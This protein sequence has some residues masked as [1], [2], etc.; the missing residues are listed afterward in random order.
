[1]SNDSAAIVSQVWT[2]A[3]VLKNAGLAYGDC[4]GHITYRKGTTQRS[5]PDFE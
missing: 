5:E 4:V 2:Y 3:H 1:M